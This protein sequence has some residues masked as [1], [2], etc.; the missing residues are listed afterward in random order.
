MRHELCSRGII[1]KKHFPKR[2]KISLLDEFHGHIGA[3]PASWQWASYAITGAIV[4]YDLHIEND[5]YFIKNI[6]LVSVPVYK[7][8]SAILYLHHVLE[9]CYFCLP[10]HSGQ[11]ECFQLLA[12]II[13]ILEHITTIPTTQKILLAKLLF[14]IGQYPHDVEQLSISNIL[15]Q[16]CEKLVN[17]TLDHNGQKEVELFI[18]QCVQSHP[19]GRLLRTVNFLSQVGH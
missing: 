14:L 15:H 13:D 6:E 19:Y 8:D 12:Y 1:I 16:P 17:L 3:V 7:N 9:I 5:L 10:V 11:Q 2:L 4:S 18:Y